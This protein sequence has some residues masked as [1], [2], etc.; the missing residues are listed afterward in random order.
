MNDLE[1]RDSGA[2]RPEAK[3]L[4]LGLIEFLDKS[5]CAFFAIENLVERLKENG[6]QQ[7]D[8]KDKFTMEPKGRYYVTRGDSSIIAIVAGKSRVS[9]AGFFMLG[10]HTDSPGF[11]LKPSP[12]K[13]EPDG[14]VTLSAEVYGGP[15]RV[16]WMDRDLGLC[17]R[18]M[19]KNSEGEVESRLYCSDTPFLS[20]PNLAIHLNREANDK[21]LTVNPQ[22]EMAIIMGD[23]SLG[24]NKAERGVKAL[25]AA[26]LGLDRESI[27]SMDLYLYDAQPAGFG[28]IDYEFIR[29]GRLDDLAMCH[30]GLSALLASLK[31]MGGGTA[32]TRILAC[33]DNEEIGSQTAQG[34]RSTFLPSILERTAMALGDDREGFLAGLAG[35]FMISADNAHARHPGY[36]SRHDPNHAPSLNKG[37]VLKLHASRAYATD[38]L[39]AAVFGQ[40]CKAAG[41]PMQEFV[42]RSDYRSGSTIGSMTSA[43]LGV[44]VADVGNPQLAM[45]SIRELA[46]TMDHLY[47]KKAMTVFLD[48]S[49]KPARG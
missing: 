10:A 15:L 43:I 41:V 21:G 22:T 32:H 25:V 16:T 9:R 26:S 1:K 6:F 19:F 24:S 12:E 7:L 30:A 34:A 20:M 38:A 35:S 17:G 49:W 8:E 14:L 40:C 45:H 36:A 23:E 42:N 27:L 47:M 37:P 11:K 33:L 4:C 18:V 2:T 29:S 39:S 31:D 48:G 46:G 13:K 44:P 28:G 5:P 3:E